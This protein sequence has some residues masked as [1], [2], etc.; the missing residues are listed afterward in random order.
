MNYD[1]NVKRLNRGEP[2]KFGSDAKFE[3]NKPPKDLLAEIAKQQIRRW[4]HGQKQIIVLKR[5]LRLIRRN[6]K[7]L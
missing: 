3:H 4:K 5:R 1:E 7:V 6:L 2:L